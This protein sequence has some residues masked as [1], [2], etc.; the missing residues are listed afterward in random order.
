MKAQFLFKSCQMPSPRWKCG[1]EMFLPRKPLLGNFWK[2]VPVNGFKSSS[3]SIFYFSMT[4]FGNEMNPHQFS[5]PFVLILLLAA[6]LV[7]ILSSC[8]AVFLKVILK[9]Y[10]ERR[11][12]Y[13][14]N[15][16]LYK[17]KK[18]YIYKPLLLVIAENGI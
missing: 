8:L 3:R 4:I 1:T 18:L 11:V 14:L 12:L 7:F 6:I 16:R 10:L 13:G 2:P 17:Q 15:L 5:L 9:I